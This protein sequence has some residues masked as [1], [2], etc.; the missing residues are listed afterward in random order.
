MS[1]PKAQVAR[2]R[3][4]GGVGALPITRAADLEPV[5]HGG[6]LDAARRRFPNAP[7]PWLDLSTGI[8]PVAYPVPP[9]AADAWARLPT[10]A[11]E[12]RLIVA[13]AMRYGARDAEMVA[14]APGTQALIQL[15]PRLVGRTRVAILGPTYD[16]HKL[17]WRRQGHE[18][19][20]SDGLEA[21][22][23]GG[24]R[25]IVA[26]NP[27]NPTGRLLSPAELRVA[28][29]HLARVGGLL[30]VDEA[31]ID[32]LPS[33]ASVVPDLPPATIVLRSFGK[34]YG[35]AGLRLG[36]AIGEPAIISRIRGEIGPWAVSGAA[37]EI[38]SAALSDD[39]W[40][41]AAR[42]RLD[43]ELQR[44][45]RILI[46]AG[47]SIVGGTPLFRLAEHDHAVRIAERLGGQGIHVRSFSRSPGWLRFGLPG[48][49]TDWQR[50]ECTLAQ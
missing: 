6:D 14:P 41:H 2:P 12:H 42:E 1:D 44:L 40:L 13:A 22:L 50:L 39:A 19:T 32:V 34:T 47:C 10:R 25:V 11:D 36:F 27:N 8:N 24:A 15:L 45:D 35:L 48:A 17:C 33:G 18:V 43:K 28:A 26:V 7:E 3:E 29:G 49:E 31:F 20:V 46:S 23:A 37:I 38:G 21:A 5:H 9:I 16:E 30:V 4:K